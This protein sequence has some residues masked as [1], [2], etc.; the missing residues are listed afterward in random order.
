MK[1]YEYVSVDKASQVCDAA[2]I[3][4]MNSVD[5]YS[6]PYE[7][8]WPRFAYIGDPYQLA[9]NSCMNRSSTFMCTN[10]LSFMECLT[11]EC[12]TLIH[13][14]NIIPTVHLNHKY[15]MESPISEL[16][17][18]KSERSVKTILHPRT[19]RYSYRAKRMRVVYSFF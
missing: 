15:R 1:R 11:Q 19:Y 4:L 6:I 5:Y 9:P 17:N 3:V 7:T 8:R 18:I 12:L 10:R 14:L 16:A 2:A 13:G